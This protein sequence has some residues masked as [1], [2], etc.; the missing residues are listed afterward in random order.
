MLLTEIMDIPRNY[1]QKL[2]DYGVTTA[3]QFYE[4][5]TRYP[6]GVIKALGIN[7]DILRALLALIERY[8]TPGL[9]KRVLDA[10]IKHKRGALA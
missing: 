10:V 6:D 4:H 5:G 1:T 2:A 8:I 9:Q 7:N 3:D